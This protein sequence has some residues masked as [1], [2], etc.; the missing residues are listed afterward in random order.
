MQQET[1]VISERMMGVVALASLTAG[2][3]TGI[4]ARIIM[5]IVALTAH[6]PTGFSI[7]GTLNILGIC[8]GFGFIVGFIIT[9]TSTILSASPK[10]GK[11]VPGPV[12]RGLILA[13]FFLLLALP[14]FININADDFTLGIPLLDKFMFGALF[15]IYAF[16]LT[17]AEKAFDHYLPRKPASA[18]ANIPATDVNEEKSTP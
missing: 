18:T 11:Y 9:M 13:L 7:A 1:I 10:A 8:I 4:V 5:R 17:I 14:I 15:V 2:I 6:Q 3:V 12:W 16:T